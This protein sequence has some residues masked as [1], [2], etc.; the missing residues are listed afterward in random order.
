[1]YGGKYGKELSK[2]LKSFLEFFERYDPDFRQK[3]FLDG[4]KDKTRKYDL[5]IEDNEIFHDFFV[6][7][8]DAIV[9][10]NCEEKTLEQEEDKI[11]KTFKTLKRKMMFTK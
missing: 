8:G 2:I 6:T 4:Y 9:T 7:Y 10:L 1:M 5:K 11:Q 3:F